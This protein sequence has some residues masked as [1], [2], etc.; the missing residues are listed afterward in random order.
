MIQILMFLVAAIAAPAE[1]LYTLPVQLHAASGKT[2]GLD[3]A[4]GHP[5]IVSMFYGSCP[6]ACPALIDDLTRVLAEAPD[7]RVVLVSFDAARD[8]PARLRQLAREHHLDARWTLAA[9]DERDARA[10]AAVLGMRYRKLAN[11]EYWHTTA[12]VVLDKDGRPIA[13][14]DRLG[15]HAALVAALRRS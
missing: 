1:S 4:R 10:V 6:A 9:A 13:R 2:V 7:A 15:D 11:G 3:V 8:T 5:V 12:I 14:S